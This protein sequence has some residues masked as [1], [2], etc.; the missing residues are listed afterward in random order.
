MRELK[1]SIAKA[2]MRAAGFE[3][4]FKPKLYPGEKWNGRRSTFARH[5][6]EWIAPVGKRGIFARARAM[7]RSRA[8]RG[9][10]AVPAI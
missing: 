5:W 6:R 7:G 10:R 8:A 2:N 9:V 3:R 4:L 1:R